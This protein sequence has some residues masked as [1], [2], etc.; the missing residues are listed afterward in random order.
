MARSWKPPEF[1]SLYERF[2]CH[3]EFQFG[4]RAYYLRYR[5]RVATPEEAS[6]MSR[7]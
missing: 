7:G 3:E 1:D 4:G 2:T 6:V 5:S